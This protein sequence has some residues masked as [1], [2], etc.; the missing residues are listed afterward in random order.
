MSINITIIKGKAPNKQ[1]NVVMK[2]CL[3]HVVGIIQSFNKHVAIRPT[4]V[5]RI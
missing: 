2:E 5:L 1:A 3:F 4:Y